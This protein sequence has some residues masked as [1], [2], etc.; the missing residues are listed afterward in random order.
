MFLFS[1]EGECGLDLKIDSERL[2][3]ELHTAYLLEYLISRT[4]KMIYYK[5]FVF[6][7]VLLNQ[8]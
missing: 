4:E 6:T 2:L 5:T 7:I 3:G 1:V 8:V